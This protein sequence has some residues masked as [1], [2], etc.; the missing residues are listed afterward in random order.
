MDHYWWV[1]SGPELEQGD[2]EVRGA[3]LLAGFRMAGFR[4][5][6]D[7]ASLHELDR[8]N[9]IIGP[10]NSGKSNVLRFIEKVL[11]SLNVGA[12][13]YTIF[14]EDAPRG[15][16]GSMR[17]GVLVPGSVWKSA[18][19][20]DAE[21]LETLVEWT[22][23]I[24]FSADGGSLV[25]S[26]WTFPYNGGRREEPRPPPVVPDRIHQKLRQ[27]GLLLDK[28]NLASALRSNSIAF[29]VPPVEAIPASRSIGKASKDAPQD[30]AGGGL[31][32]RLARL[33]NPSSPGTPTYE[34]AKKAWE[35]YRLFVAAVLEDDGVAIEVPR[36][37]DTIHITMNGRN[38]PI[39]AL[40]TGIH[41]LLMLAAAC[42]LTRESLVLIEEPE[43][44]LHP[45]LLRK[46]GHFLLEQ[47][48]N[49]YF[50]ATHSPHLI[51]M[52]STRVFRTR[53]A[54]GRTVVERVDRSQEVLSLLGDLGYRASDVLQ[55]N[56]VV[57]VEG[58]SDRIYIQYWLEEFDPELVL[59]V[60]YS[61]M[62]YGGANV[63]SISGAPDDVELP[64]DL[65]RL[66]RIN[67]YSA[68]VA[69][70]D[71]RK[72]GDPL[73]SSLKEARAE[74]ENGGFVWVTAGREVE[75]YVDVDTML[76]AIR[77]SNK[78]AQ[79]LLGSGDKFDCRYSYVGGK[80]AEVH[81]PP[82]GKPT[83]ARAVVEQEPSLD[84]LDLRERLAALSTFIRQANGLAAVDHS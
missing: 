34:S 30:W 64:A 32:R 60:H 25:W 56:C 26:D 67:Q 70:S 69:D 19:S 76:N 9:L 11:P 44:H 63:R 17:A 40:G 29:R 77:V 51:D 78:N 74:F 58:P 33:Q 83:L 3:P 47:T 75:N 39:E 28:A 8:V 12:S 49:Q 45:L 23:G 53:L 1:A 13:A 80:G 21:Q 71:K 73:K 18:R 27:Q 14:P 79:E 38:M 35:D 48:T 4:S 16:D 54:D 15:S 6:Y 20:L 55:A 5:I 7:E 24:G 2:P 82:E 10:N 68:L 84:V 61:I 57:W 59:D 31:F 36:D 81:A 52:P 43:V 66:R 22:D 72:P 37:E 42:V 65:I 50:I 46:F 62:F 41:Q